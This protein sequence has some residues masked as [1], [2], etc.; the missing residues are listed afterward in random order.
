[1]N[2][3]TDFLNLKLKN[4]IIIASSPLSESVENIVKCY[5]SGASGIIVK[6]C[7][8]FDSKS[9]GF[10][11]C[12]FDNKGFWAASTFDREILEIK[13]A[14]KLLTESVKNVDIPIFA[15]VTEPTLDFNTW[16]NTCKIVSDSGIKGIQLDFFYLENLIAQNDFNEK[17][18][19][20]INNL[21]ENIDLPLFP[22]LNI[23]LP[24][25]Y[26][27]N[28][29]HKTKIK[30]VSL[31][32]SISIPPPIDI[33]NNGKQKLLNVQKPHN[34][35]CFGNWQYSLTKK[36]TYEFVNENFETCSGGGIVEWT[37]IIEL[38]MLGA[39]A[40]QIA[41]DFLINGLSRIKYH[42]DNIEKYL[43]ENNFNNI[44]KIRGLALKDFGKQGE[45][46]FHANKVKH[47]QLKCKKCKKCVEQ[48]FCNN[49]KFVD[50]ELIINEDNCEGCNFCISICKNSA[51]YFE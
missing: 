8:S 15:S 49:F 41:S 42:V 14:H 5:L 34:I 48:T 12:Y 22:K 50:N 24:S 2:L 33:S 40:I 29:L 20:L 13:S 44:Q 9:K 38:L 10:R 3:Q 6:S 43:S 11:R 26:I 7:S 1:M 16:F 39:S 25:K 4:P 32:D 21:T 45:I 18:I 47:N 27:A 31:L 46:V 17:F 23:N 30:S 36:Y 37:E 51:L 35:S 28:L 19:D